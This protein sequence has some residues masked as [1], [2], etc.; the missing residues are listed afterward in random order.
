MVI[1]EL[2]HAIVALHKAGLQAC[3]ILC[4]LRHLPVSRSM[5]YRTIRRYTVTGSVN[6]R[7]NGGSRP[8]AAAP[9]MVR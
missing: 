1:E 4:H 9:A 5:V 2:Y 3:Q 6:K 8:T 7:H